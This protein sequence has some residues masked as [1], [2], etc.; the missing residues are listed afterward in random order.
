MREQEASRIAD[1]VTEVIWKKEEAI[2]DVADKVHELCAAFPIYE[3][4]IL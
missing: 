1:L 4:D 2:A 3:G